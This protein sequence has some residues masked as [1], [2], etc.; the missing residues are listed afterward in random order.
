R[1]HRVKRRD[2]ILLTSAAIARPLVGAAQQSERVRHI[3]LL[4]PFREDD[5][6][7]RSRLAAFRQ[8]L[9]ELGWTEGRNIRIEYRFT[10][11]NAEHTRAAAVELTSHAPDVLVAY[12]NPAVSALQ[13]VTRTIPIVFTQVSDPLGSGFVTAL[14]RPGGN[15]T[16][17]HSFK[18]AMGK[19]LQLLREIAPALGRAAVVYD[20]NII[21]NVRFLRAAEASASSLGMI[22][23]AAGVRDGADIERAL[24]G[25][26]AQ[27]DGGLV[28]A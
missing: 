28:V 18:P 7:T 25:F 5:P 11:G 27:P 8:T 6:E 20:P 13:S 17:F 14:A 21:A 3:G 23:T 12:A 19:W 26:A 9:Q 10:D 1:G 22:V 4:S 15:T 16:G 2:F 24:T